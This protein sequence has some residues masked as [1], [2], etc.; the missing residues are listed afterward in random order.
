MTDRTR[1]L[2]VVL[3]ED[4]RVDDAEAVVNAIKMIRCVA[5]VEVGP[6][7]AH[8]ARQEAKVE[9]KREIFDFVQELLSW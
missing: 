3:E 1:H 4:M 9:L 8:M 2:T 6:P 7:P 5:E